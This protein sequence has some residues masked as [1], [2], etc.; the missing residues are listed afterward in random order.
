MRNVTWNCRVWKG[1]AV[2]FLDYIAALQGVLA[3]ALQAGL[4]VAADLQERPRGTTIGYVKSM[5]L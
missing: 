2:S 1:F 3:Q 4:V 5:R